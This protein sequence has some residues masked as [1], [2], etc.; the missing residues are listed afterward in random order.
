MQFIRISSII[1]QRTGDFGDV[2][3]QG[4][5]VGFAI[6]PRFNRGEGLGMRVYHGGEF[7]YQSTTVG[8][9]E[10]APC[11][12]FEGRAGGGDGEVDVCG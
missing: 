12:S 6:V 11:G 9:R 3:G 2:L 4:D 7:V 8:G 1:P 5:L 10:G